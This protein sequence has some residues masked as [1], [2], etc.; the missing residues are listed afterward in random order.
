[1][2]TSWG[3]QMTVLITVS[4]RV[5]MLPCFLKQIGI[6]FTTAIG[7][8]YILAAIAKSAHFRSRE[9]QWKVLGFVT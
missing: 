5:I 1:M 7:H 9:S 4:T 3:T 6:F 8:L 2:G